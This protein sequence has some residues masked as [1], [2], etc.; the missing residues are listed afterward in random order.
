MGRG[1]GYMGI[2]KGQK[3]GVDGRGRRNG[4]GKG[5]EGMGRGKGD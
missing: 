4:L 1:K 5:A 2:G 3:E